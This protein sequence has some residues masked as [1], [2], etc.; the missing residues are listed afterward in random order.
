MEGYGKHD[1]LCGP[2]SGASLT[3]TISMFNE[4]GIIPKLFAALIYQSIKM[5]LKVDISQHPLLIAKPFYWRK[6]D[7]Q[8]IK[9]LLVGC[10]NLRFINFTDCYWS[11]SIVY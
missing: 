8:E 11:F 7:K 3:D 9:E 4:E 6:K 2:R 1:I 5:D 10:H